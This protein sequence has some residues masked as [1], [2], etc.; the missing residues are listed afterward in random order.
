MNANLIAPS[1]SGAKLTFSLIDTWRIE[2]GNANP[3]VKINNQSIGTEGGIRQF[4]ESKVIYG[5]TYAT[6]CGKD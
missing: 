2:Y 3:D 5:A 6:L 1:G 4:A